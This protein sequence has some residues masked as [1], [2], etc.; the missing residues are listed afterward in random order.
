[1]DTQAT[2]RKVG[3]G[4]LTMTA[5]GVLGPA[6]VELVRNEKYFQKSLDCVYANGAYNQKD[7]NEDCLALDYCF[8]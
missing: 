3:R 1:M 2:G 6:D 7:R 5:L 8:Q 4:H